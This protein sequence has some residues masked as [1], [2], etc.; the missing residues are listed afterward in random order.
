MLSNENKIEDI[1]VFSGLEFSNT[2]DDPN[3][4]F[5]EDPTNKIFSDIFDEEELDNIKKNKINVSFI[6]ETIYE[7]DSIGVVKLKIFE[8][9]ERKA[10]MS[11]LYLFCLNYLSLNPGTV[12]QKLTQYNRWPLNKSRL[13]Q[14]ILN[15]YDKNGVLIDF[16]KKEQYVFDDILELRLDETPYM[17]SKPL[18]MK[19]L[20]EEYPFI[21]NP[22]L[23]IEHNSLLDTFDKEK[24]TINNNL[25]LETG[26]FFKNNI[27]LC[28]ASD[29]FEN[30]EKKTT[31]NPKLASKIYFPLLY[32]DN[33]ENIESLNENQSKL[34]TYT[35]EKITK[36]TKKT[37]DNINLFHQIYK[38]QT[39]SDNFSFNKKQTGIN[40]FKATIY[41]EFKI[42]IPIESIFKLIHA[43]ENAPLLKYNPEFRQENMYRLYAPKLTIDGQNIPH[44][45]KSLIFKLMRIIGKNKCVAI[46]TVIKY[47]NINFNVICEF[48]EDGKIMVYPFT[49]IE[50]PIN[51]NNV[52]EIIQLAVN[53]LIEQIKPFFEQSGLEIPLFVSVDH[54]NVEVRE[55]QFQMVYKITQKFDVKK[56]IGCISSVFT[57]E[58]KNVTKDIKLRY[59][60]VTNYNKRESQEAFII[61]KIDQGFKMEEII[62]ELVQQ[63]TDLNEADATELISKIRSE[64]NMLGINKKQSLINKINPGFETI[65]FVNT[66]N[67]NLTVTVNGINNVNYLKT[68]PVY[69]DSI[70]R[71]IQ[72]I[73]SCG[74]EPNKINKLCAGKE[75]KDVEFKELKPE[76]MKMEMEEMEMEDS[77]LSPIDDDDLLWFQKADEGEDEEE[78]NISGGR[79]SRG[80]HMR[81]KYK[82]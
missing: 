75:L 7:D 49:N 65:M 51:L 43:T 32:Y 9:I 58:S 61:E 45:E 10:S 63:Y 2:D 39:S 36:D 34:I 28:L 14:L 54:P 69:V 16:K 80:R 23:A 66:V 29:V 27:Y 46:Y 4:L 62:S 3:E 57:I 79:R 37:F 48:Y 40:F 67:S 25:L 64:I 35:S 77:Y 20:F 78:P 41:S 47:N 17:V 74:V 19:N 56:I 13:N 44:L 22:F 12:Y 38:N 1:Y 21:S 15:L 53:P 33:I 18:G 26:D 71:I 60:R 52:N 42:K 6:D 59:K 8:A 72:D 30:I 73:S 50:V 68:I 76:I 82:K 24:N 5:K 55:I 81:N 31:E 11:E 70:V